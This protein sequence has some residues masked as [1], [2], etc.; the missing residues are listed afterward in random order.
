MRMWAT[1]AVQIGRAGGDSRAS[2]ERR[3]KNRLLLTGR[4]ET[5]ESERI[6]EEQRI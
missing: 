2:R 6:W 4:A 5:A 1:A 3:R